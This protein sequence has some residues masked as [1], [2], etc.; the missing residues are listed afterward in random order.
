MGKKI[1]V[2]RF[3][4]FMCCLLLTACAGEKSVSGILNEGMAQ[5][6]EGREEEPPE[7]MTSEEVLDYLIENYVASRTEPE[8]KILTEDEIRHIEET[9]DDNWQPRITSREQLKEVIHNMLKN[10]KS[11]EKYQS[12]NHYQITPDEMLR[13]YVELEDEDPLNAICV[14]RVGYSEEYLTLEYNLDEGVINKMKAETERLLSLAEKKLR[15]DLKSDYEKI[16]TVNNYLCDLITYP[17]EEPYPPESHTP[18]GAFENGSAVCDGYAKSAKLLLAGAGVDTRVIVGTCTNGEG[19]AWNMVKLEDR[20]YHLDICW[21][22]GAGNWDKDGRKEYFLVTDQY[23]ELSR[24]WDAGLYP[25]S[26]STNY[27]P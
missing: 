26:S 15:L 24:S 6:G 21:N 2:F 23:I 27:Q 3:M 5:F 18:Y 14:S 7:F 19:H 10:T 4:L 8:I 9:S 22:D 13:I 12:D 11:A 1:N 17:S 20:W 16:W 25:K